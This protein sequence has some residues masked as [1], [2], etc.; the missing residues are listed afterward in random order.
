MH[1]LRNAVLKVTVIC[2]CPWKAPA[3]F[4]LVERCGVMD[5][6]LARPSARFAA[7]GVWQRQRSERRVCRGG[8][9]ALGLVTAHLLPGNYFSCRVGEGGKPRSQREVQLAGDAPRSHPESA[10]PPLCLP[11]QGLHASGF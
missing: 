2:F 6:A 7:G 1:L 4:V 8:F 10:R 3:E 11:V 5:E 9:A